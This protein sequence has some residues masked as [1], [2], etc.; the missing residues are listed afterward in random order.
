MGRP[1]YMEDTP[2]GYMYISESFSSDNAIQNID[3]KRNNDL[4]YV[5]FDTNLQDF[6]V[7]N[8]NKRYYDAGN[9]ME[10]I[11]SEKIQSLLRTGGWFGE[12][13]HPIPER[14]SD[15]FSPERI[16]NVPPEKRAF[17]IMSP[18]LCGNVLKAKIQSAQGSVGESFGKE[19]LAG[20]IPQFSCRAIANMVSKNGKPYVNVKRLITYD[21]PWYPS[22]AIAHATS[23]PKV[24]T[25]SFTESVG[26]MIESATDYINGVMIPLKEILMDVGHKDVNAGLILEAFDLSLDNLC[27]FDMAKEHVIIRD[28]NNVIYAN[29]NPNTVKKV[30]E[31]YNSFNL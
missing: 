7:M 12:F 16:Q 13:E 28:E 3:T 5:T 2:M 26:S 8:R 20:W 11:K 14:V 23:K 17:K 24:I 15:K 27:G 30:N 21:A 1:S 31:F 4:W 18:S 19:V 22:H 9:I 25:K 29:I 6:D 10:C